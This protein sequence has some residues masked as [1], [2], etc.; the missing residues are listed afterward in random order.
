VD[1]WIEEYSKERTHTGKD[2]FGRTPWQTFEETKHLAFE[3]MLDNTQPTANRAV[4]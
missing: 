2:C 1:K 4:S 3:K